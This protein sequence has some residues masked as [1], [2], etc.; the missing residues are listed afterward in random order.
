MSEPNKQP[1]DPRQLA[2]NAKVV[3][4]PA[5]PAQGQKVIVKG[6]ATMP[7]PTD[8]PPPKPETIQGP[9]APSAEFAK[10]NPAIVNAL[11][12]NI[13]HQEV[14]KIDS[15]IPQG[16]IKAEK[17]D[18]RD[19]K[20]RFTEGNVPTGHRQKKETSPDYW[21]EQEGLKAYA[22]LP[23]G[24]IVKKAQQIA[25]ALMEKAVDGNLKAIEIAFSRLDGKPMQKIQVVAPEDA[26]G[27]V[28]SA[29]AEAKLE[30]LFGR[31]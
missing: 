31:K 10:N 23:D 9:K 18:G 7:K 16:Q 30:S 3:V 11:I 26:E 5:K 21:L 8:N 2:R 20:G 13:P 24:T 15:D 6:L 29:E 12:N 17:A 22:M 19:E 28:L 14:K 25:R 27:T 1:I 4:S